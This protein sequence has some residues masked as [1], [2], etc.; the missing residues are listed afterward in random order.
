MTENIETS[1]DTTTLDVAD[2]GRRTLLRMTATG[3]AAATSTAM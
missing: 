2:V 3:I 1:G